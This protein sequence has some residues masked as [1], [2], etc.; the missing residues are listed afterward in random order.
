[1][2]PA[3]PTPSKR[4]PETSP[5]VHHSYPAKAT[6]GYCFRTPYRRLSTRGTARGW[7]PL[8][9]GQCQHGTHFIPS[10]EHVVVVRHLCPRV[11]RPLRPRSPEILDAA[12]GADLRGHMLGLPP[13][14]VLGAYAERGHTAVAGVLGVVGG[15]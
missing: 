12:P 14:C 13:V 1:M 11:R 4:S 10:T 8:T 7:E 15:G 3:T 6:R 9:K 2:L 5:E